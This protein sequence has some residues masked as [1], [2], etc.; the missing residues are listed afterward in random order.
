MIP[1]NLNNTR[2]G[3]ITAT[4][5]RIWSYRSEAGRPERGPSTVF[6]SS[7]LTGVLMFYAMHSGVKYYFLTESAKCTYGVQNCKFIAAVDKGPT[8][9]LLSQLNPLARCQKEIGIIHGGLET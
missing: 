5:I 9:A 8:V 1:C 7:S 2:L 6:A 3:F 4:R